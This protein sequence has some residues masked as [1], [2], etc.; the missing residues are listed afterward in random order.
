LVQS[1]GCTRPIS[2]T[3]TGNLPRPDGISV[4]SREL[5]SRNNVGENDE[6][7]YLYVRDGHIEV[8][9]SREVLHLGRGEVGYA[10]GTGAAVRPDFVPRFIDFDRIPLPNSSNPNLLTTLL[11]ST[12]VRSG[13]QCR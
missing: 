10:D 13:P 6:G 7:L 11:T 4:N 9:S 1:D 5:F 3:P 2:Q 8:T 12:P